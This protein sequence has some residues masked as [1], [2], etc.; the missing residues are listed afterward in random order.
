MAR[1]KPEANTIFKPDTLTNAFR[2]TSPGTNTL[3]GILDLETN[4]YIH[5]DLDQDG[6]PVARANYES[7]FRE[8]Q[9]YIQPPKFSVYDLVLLHLESRGNLVGS[10]EKA[11]VVLD[12]NTFKTYTDILEWMGV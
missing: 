1:E 11:K 8:I 4:E 12:R 6:I 5:L 3:I 2:L 10:P 7:T 9:H